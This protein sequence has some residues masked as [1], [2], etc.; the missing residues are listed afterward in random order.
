MMIGYF[1]WM[2]GAA[3][4][5]VFVWGK[6]PVYNIISGLDNGICSVCTLLEPAVLKVCVLES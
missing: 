3:V 1:Y 2:F 6:D 5:V 4:L